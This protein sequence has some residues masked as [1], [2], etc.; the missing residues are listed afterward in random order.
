[1][2]KIFLL[3]MAMTVFVSAFGVQVGTAR[4]DGGSLIIY[5]DGLFVWGKGIVFIF[6]ATGYRN[7]DLKDASIYV[8]SDFYDLFC[9]VLKEEGKIVC[10]AQ[11]GLT[12]FAGQTGIIYLGGQIFYVIIP[13]R[14][15]APDGSEVPTCSE[16]EVLGA[17]Y[18]VDFGFGYDGPYFVPGDTLEEADLQ[19]ESWYGQSPFRRI[20]GLVCDQPPS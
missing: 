11:G 20:S 2:K 3:L 1:M 8:G 7:K 16:G 5:S 12:Q 14:S 18:E 6:D 13:A 19:A 4:A 10:N 17:Y 9:W 15:D